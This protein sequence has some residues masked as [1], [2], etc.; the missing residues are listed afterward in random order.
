M[1]KKELLERASWF[2]PQAILYEYITV[3][4]FVAHANQACFVTRGF[5]CRDLKKPFLSPPFPRAL[6]QCLPTQSA[7]HS[8]KVQWRPQYSSILY[9]IIMLQW[10]TFSVQLSCF[11]SSQI[12][13]PRLIQPLNQP[14][15][16]YAIRKVIYQS[17]GIFLLC[18]LDTYGK[19]WILWIMQVVVIKSCVVITHGRSKDR[20][21]MGSSFLL[22]LCPIALRFFWLEKKQV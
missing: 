3:H 22:S 14:L 21:M 7:V 15:G 8:R 18:P 4:Q 12:R 5:Y 19:A 17:T 20:A 1:K 16:T 11:C 2:L 13:R 6:A 9:S 10:P